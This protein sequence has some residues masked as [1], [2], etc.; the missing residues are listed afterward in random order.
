[1]MRILLSSQDQEILQINQEI[2]QRNQEKA[3]AR[4]QQIAMGLVG[5]RS[6]ILNTLFQGAVCLVLIS[7]HQEARV[8]ISQ[9][10]QE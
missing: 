9:L 5:I 6:A 4:L 10:N 1:M 8:K 7:Q 2:L 3:H